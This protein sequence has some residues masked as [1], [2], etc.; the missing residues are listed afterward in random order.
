M[1]KRNSRALRESHQKYETLVDSGPV[2]IGVHQDGKWMKLNKAAVRLLGYDSEQ[3]LLGKSVLDVVHP[4]F[5]TGVAGRVAEMAR[6]G[7]PAPLLEEKL[8]KKDGSVIQ[9]LISGAPILYEGKPA[10]QVVALDVS[11]LRKSQWETEKRE[12]YLEAVLQNSPD[13]VVTLDSSHRI[14]EWNDGAERIFGYAREEVLGRNIDHLIARKGVKKEAVRLTQQVMSG[15]RVLPREAVRYRKDGRPVN[16]I[17][18]GS[19]VQVEGEFVGV[20]A[21]YTDITEL[22][23]AQEKSLTYAG[24]MEALHA[25]TSVLVSS[26]DYRRTVERCAHQARELI[27]A[28]GVVIYQLNKE[29]KRLEPMVAKAPHADQ[30]MAMTLRLGEGLSGEVALSGKPDMVN[31]IDLTERGKQVPGT[32]VEPESLLSVPLKIKDEVI[33]VVTVDRLGEREFARSDLEF[34]EDLANIS[35]VAIHN[36]HLYDQAQS[37]IKHRKQIQDELRESEA[38][39]RGIFST[40]QH[41]FYRLSPDDTFLMVNP[42]MVAM[43]GCSSEKDL[44]GK[45]ICELGFATPVSRKQLTGA[46]EKNGAMTSLE[47]E[48]TTRD[49]SVITVVENIRPV[50]GKKGEILYY[51]GSVQDITRLKELE[52]QVIRTQKLELIGSLGGKIAHEIN[53]RLTAAMGYTDLSLVKAKSGDKLHKYLTSIRSNLRNAAGV[54][55]QLLNVTRRQRGRPGDFQ[56]NELIESMNDIM[57]QIISETTVLKTELDRGDTTVHADPRLIE[58]MITNLVSNARDAMPEG[59]ELR[60]STSR[61]NVKKSPPG[62]DRPLPP[63]SYVMLEIADSGTGVSEDIRQKMFDPFFTTKDESLATGLG[64]S[65]VQVIVAESDGAVKAWSKE[66]KGTTFTILLP[67]AGKDRKKE[68]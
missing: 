7:R 28:D 60:I 12:K 22:K 32:P 62:F 33:G 65:T 66:G 56:L 23:K 1:A 48:W 11:S 5:R 39:F 17:V 40:M 25:A 16:V 15:K 61:K 6:T 58:Q 37:E 47:S 68:S 55:Q 38:L 49:G 50:R 14:L 29:K 44:I 53:N 46:F 10:F 43:L 51:E 57:N 18:A 35:A 20:V 45:K 31:R 13:A 3:E 63:G 64:L 41:G 26:L 52:N 19:P 4:D 42:A 24:R 36:S 21:V 54:T 27:G 8:L 2:A 59:G 67:W 9:A 30:I 34:L